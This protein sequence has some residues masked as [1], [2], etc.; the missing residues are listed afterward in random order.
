MEEQDYQHINLR[1]LKSLLHRRCVQ[2][3]PTQASIQRSSRDP[4]T[5]DS[6]RKNR[7]AATLRRCSA[8]CLACKKPTHR[9]GSDFFY[10]PRPRPGLAPSPIRPIHQF[11]CTYAYCWTCSH[12]LYIAWHKTIETML[13]LPPEPSIPRKKKCN[14][15]R[16]VGNEVY[17]KKRWLM[18]CRETYPVLPCH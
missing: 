12:I 9:T 11:A 13:I 2:K 16:L 15:L 5:L 1:N 18:G 14:L 8:V 6:A 3:M 10:P 4:R 17:V 7:S